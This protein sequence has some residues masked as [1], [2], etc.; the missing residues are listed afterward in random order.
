MGIS[1]S[2]FVHIMSFFTQVAFPLAHSLE[3]RSSTESFAEQGR[4]WVVSH[5]SRVAYHFTKKVTITKC[6]EVTYKWT[7]RSLA[8]GNEKVSSLHYCS[9]TALQM[10]KS[11]S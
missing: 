10:G 2:Q 9:I 5:V 7:E 8:Y 4:N 6:W 11:A 3:T 1:F